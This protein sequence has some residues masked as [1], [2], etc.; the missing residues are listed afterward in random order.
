MLAYVF[1]HYPLASASTAD[2]E[3]ALCGFHRALAAQEREWFLG[4]AVFGIAGAPWLGAH[5]GYED[6]YLLPDFAALGSLNEAAVTEGRKAS[7]DAAARLAEGGAGGVYRLIRGRGALHQACWA[8][9]LGKPAGMTYTA[10]FDQLAGPLERSGASLW[11]RQMT[12]GPATEFCAHG[13]APLAIPVEF[14]SLAVALRR[15]A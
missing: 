9:W 14:A 6:W 8:M 7:H 11:Q 15:V 4:S 3:E 13:E 10:F 1:W 5:E 12:L 2:Y